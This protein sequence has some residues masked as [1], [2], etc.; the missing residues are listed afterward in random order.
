[1]NP[2]GVTKEEEYYGSIPHSVLRKLSK[3]NIPVI[4]HAKK[5]SSSPRSLPDSSRDTDIIQEIIDDKQLSSIKRET[6]CTSILLG[7]YDTMP[8]HHNSIELLKSESMASSFDALPQELTKQLAH[9]NRHNHQSRFLEVES[10]VAPIHTL[11]P[12]R[13]LNEEKL[14][15]LKKEKNI[16]YSWVFKSI[17]ENDKELMNNSKESQM[18]SSTIIAMNRTKELKQRSISKAIKDA[19]E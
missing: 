3:R 4:L 15:L 13:I 8:K 17:K 19:K 5:L 2:K 14:R 9:L 12:A 6:I 11:S 1:M 10:S 16:S 18:I 7:E